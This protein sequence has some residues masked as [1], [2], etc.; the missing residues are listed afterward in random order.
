MPF[1]P[2]SFSNQNK[3]FSWYKSLIRYMKNAWQRY[4]DDR[5]VPDS[6]ASPSETKTLLAKKPG[7]L[8]MRSDRI[9]YVR[10]SILSWRFS[11]EENENFF[12][13]FCFT[14]PI[15]MYL[16]SRKKKIH[17]FKIWKLID[18][19]N[20]YTSTSILNFRYNIFLVL[21][22]G[23]SLKQMQFVYQVS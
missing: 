7:H 13:K 15:S 4:S 12:L 6:I 22:M 11:L 8:K 19:S 16:Q 18:Y 5:K 14:T 21:P 20:S 3:C 10:M 1:L 2:A 9:S 17:N 23:G